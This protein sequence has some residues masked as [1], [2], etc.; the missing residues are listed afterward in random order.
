MCFLSL[1]HKTKPNSDCIAVLDQI[2]V[3]TFT[4]TVQFRYGTMQE[5]KWKYGIQEVSLFLTT[6]TNFYKA[7]NKTE[8]IRRKN[9][10]EGDFVLIEY[11][12]RVAGTGEI[13]D[14]TDAETAKREGVFN[15]NQKYEP[16]LVIIGAKMVIPG[17]EKQ[18]EEMKPG[19]EREF[20]VKPQDAFGS[21][22]PRLIKIIS[23]ANFLRQRINPVPGIFV[24]IDG[25]QAKIRSVSGGR[26]RVDFNH[27]LAGKELRYE[28]KII[29]HITKT[30][31]K[32]DELLKHY[33]LKTE[34]ILKG[35]TLIIKTTKPL[36]NIVRQ[37]IEKPIKKWI[38]EIKRI[39][40]EPDA[41][42]EG[43]EKSEETTKKNKTPVMTEKN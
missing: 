14:L 1:L 21:R 5:I 22:N 7:V 27:P 29:K 41:G 28:L 20:S 32:A 40:F 26:V 37:L 11:V 15:S 6:V 39:K 36:D 2:T 9:M 34:T 31:E 38:K 3:Q 24:T 35:N 25:R 23:R 12:G 16:V 17:I 18:L 42:S 33:R 30:K 19:D 43:S 4:G 10:K 8:A 13:F